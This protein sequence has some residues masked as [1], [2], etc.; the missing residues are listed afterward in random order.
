MLDP[1]F[2]RLLQSLKQAKDIDDLANIS[3][4]NM[5]IEEQKET[6]FVNNTQNPSMLMQVAPSLLSANFLCLKDEIES[7]VAGGC[8]LLHID[9]MDGHFVPNITLGPCV[10]EQISSITQIPLD[11]HFMV[12]NADFFVDLYAPLQPKYMSVHIE[13]ERHLHR[14]IQK[15][16][17]HGISPSIAINPHTALEGLKYIIADIDMVLIM[18]VNPGFGGQQFI[19]SMIEK[20]T[21]LKEMILMRNPQCLIEVDG[22]INE[23]NIHA[24]KNVGVDIAVAGSYIFKQKDRKIAIQS[25]KI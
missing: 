7:V 24:L 4:K 20:I 14:L 9:V 1:K 13:S 18:S 19:P 16:R 25:L 21:D 11:I 2:E 12:E 3:M 23:T 15:I 5:D 6:L 17:S 10:L 22:G 8:D